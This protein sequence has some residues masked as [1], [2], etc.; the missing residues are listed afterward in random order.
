[1]CAAV[2]VVPD[3]ADAAVDYIGSD[4]RGDVWNIENNTVIADS[5]VVD[6]NQVNV[7]NSLVLTNAGTI[8]G[9]VN[10]C[11]G[12]D[13][14]VQNTGNINAMFDATGDNSSVIQLVRNNADLN[15]LGVAGG[16]EG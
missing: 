10:V 4:I 12:C 1:M 11:D 5:V 16:A 2:S 14:Y 7:I 6:V 9:R 13:V 15:P 3:V 8:N